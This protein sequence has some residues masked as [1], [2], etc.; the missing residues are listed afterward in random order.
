VA[1]DDRLTLALRGR[2]LPAE[3]QRVLAAFA[4]QAA[5]VLERERL[6][7]VAAEADRLAEGNRIR[8]ALLAAVSHDLRTP[9][10]GIKAA[11]SSL[12]EPDLDLSPEDRSELLTVIEEGIDRLDRLVA[13]LLD[14]SRLQTKVV[15]PYARA[16][17]LDEVVPA[18]IDGVPGGDAVRLD[19]PEALAPVVADPGLLERVIANVV[20]NA[21]KHTPP[22]TEIT[23]TA[24]ALRDRV[25][26]RVVDR[27]RGVPDADKERIFAPFQRL[28]DAPAGTGV[29]L[30][31]AV[32]RGFA[33]AMDGTLVPEDTPGGGLTMVLSLPC[34]GV[35]R[36]EGS[37]REQVAP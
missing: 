32:A 28:G 23:V 5:Q 10:A 1:L 33:E 31:L 8:T 19:V 2:A 4:A 34:A 22:G 21:V 17:S 37:E 30:G 35:P 36:I 25:E 29:G 26:L 11:A 7:E 9:L 3:Q 6:R 15:Q 18:A 14:L 12:L 27:G 16:V 24:S 13:N 20:E